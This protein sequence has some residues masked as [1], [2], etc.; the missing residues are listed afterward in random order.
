MS[1]LLLAYPMLH[2]DDHARLREYRQKHAQQTAIDPHFTIV[3]PLHDIAAADFI[4]HVKEKVAGWQAFNF[5]LRSAVIQ[6]DVDGSSYY[7]Y[8]V[9]DK[10]YSNI[11]RLH[12]HLYTGLLA[13]QLRL[14]IPFIPHI[15]IGH[16]A[17]AATCK[18]MA[19]WWNAT[20]FEIKGRVKTLSIVEANNNEVA[21]LAEIELKE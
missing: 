14:D 11:I 19:D 21:T 18:A 6:G 2:P 15:T 7:T 3:F 8:L 10:G 17:D 12:D 1:L 16:A 20:P 5:V 4:A 13:E 9:P